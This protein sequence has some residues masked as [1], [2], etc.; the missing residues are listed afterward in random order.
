MTIPM[1]AFR[2]KYDLAM[3]DPADYPF[4]AFSSRDLFCDYEVLRSFRREL[5]NYIREGRRTFY[6]LQDAFD[7]TEN[8]ITELRAELERRGDWATMLFE[9]QQNRD[10]NAFRGA[11]VQ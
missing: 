7:G 9:E 8:M 1:V 2:T 3:T 4:S 5:N 11:R 6:R 10:N